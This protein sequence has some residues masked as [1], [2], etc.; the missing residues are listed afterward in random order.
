M[1]TATAFITA[2]SGHPN[3]GGISPA[4]TITLWENS[5]PAWRFQDHLE[6]GR[7]ATWIPWRPETI[8]E[9]GLLQLAAVGMRDEHVVGLLEGTSG[10]AWRADHVDLGELPGEPTAE[11][12]GAVHEAIG[13][14]KLVLTVLPESSLTHQLDLLENVTCDVE[15]CVPTYWR[16]S[17]QWSPTTDAGGTL[18]G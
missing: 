15:V 17:S 1:G 9:D 11:L 13:L 3:H 10:D 2:G 12:R 14:T 8:F 6:D 18:P 16:R 7:T 5:R 4:A